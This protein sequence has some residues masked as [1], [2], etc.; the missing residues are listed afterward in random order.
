LAADERRLNLLQ[1][2]LPETYTNHGLNLT[3]R[4]VDELRERR[5][6][7]YSFLYERLYDGTHDPI[8]VK[9]EQLREALR[10]AF[11]SLGLS[12]NACIGRFLNEVPPLNVSQHDEPSRYF[13]DRLA[14]AIAERDGKIIRHYEYAL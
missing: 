12:P 1:Q 6:G 4:C 10:S 3:K 5:V 11:A 14:T 9:V 7:F 2:A 13:D 8:I